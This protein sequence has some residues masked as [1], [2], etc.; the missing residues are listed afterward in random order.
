MFAAAWYASKLFLYDPLG[1]VVGEKK[2]FLYSE[3]V[4]ENRLSVGDDD[5]RRRAERIKD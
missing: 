2:V 1:N 4:K 3:K 5:E